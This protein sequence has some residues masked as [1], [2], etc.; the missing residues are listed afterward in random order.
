MTGGRWP[1]G[2]RG[3]VAVLLVLYAL[4]AV[5][6][7]AVVSW[8]RMPLAAYESGSIL[9]QLVVQPTATLGAAV[10]MGA[11]LIVAASVLGSP[12]GRTGW[13]F[14]GAK[15]LRVLAFTAALLSVWDLA[16]Q[17]VNPLHGSPF[18]LERVWMVVSLVAL[19]FR[20]A[21]AV[22]LLPVLVTWSAQFRIPLLNPSTF[23][24]EI[25]ARLLCCLVAFLAARRWVPARAHH[26]LH[27]VVFTL[28]VGYFW[29][30]VGKVRIGWLS[31]PYL[32]HLWT[33]AHANG[34][35]VL[36]A[37][38]VMAIS[39]TLAPLS[40]PLMV[41]ALGLELVVGG[42]LLGRR[43]LIAGLAFFIAFH[44]G[45]FLMTGMGFWKWMVFEAVLIGVLAMH[46]WKP[47]YG[48]LPA[49]LCL[50]MVLLSGSWS[51]KKNLTW[52]DV[53]VSR[54]YQLTVVGESGREYPVTAAWFEPWDAWVMLNI[55]N[56]LNPFPTTT[57]LWGCS[58][59]PNY[60][61][62]VVGITGE[63]DYLAL[64]T[65]WA[66]VQHNDAF[67]EK[68]DRMMRSIVRYR[69]ANPRPWFTAMQPPHQ[70]NQYPSLDP[71]VDEPIHQLVVTEV[72]TLAVPEYRE[73][74]RREVRRLTVEPPR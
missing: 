50:T 49:A 53:P 22:L 42:A 14:A 44:G 39:R 63:E 19:W 37:D 8:G 48:K 68:W 3:E 12:E 5:V 72:T 70:L 57:P 28:A 13:T 15:A 54:T 25:L 41:G 47:L 46:D 71:T 56:G 52:F 18:Y 51:R 11:Y 34:W 61:K 40:L 60:A 6:D 31:H 33:H 32:H 58:M 27:L 64:E 45:I 59:R 30:G 73:I 66:K 10:G 26:V 43:T 74:R 1:T 36:S 24:H 16:T 17:D 7:A 23:E 29:S 35:Q 20:P 38:T 69:N 4:L 62:R 2:W 55:W 21:A 67:T 65:K 9:L